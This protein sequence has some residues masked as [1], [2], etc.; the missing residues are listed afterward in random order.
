M[1]FL[2]PPLSHHL[3][4]PLLPSP[5]YP[6][7]SIPSSPTISLKPFFSSFPQGHLLVFSHTTP[8]AV[9]P[10]SDDS[11]PSPPIYDLIKRHSLFLL[12]FVTYACFLAASRAY[13]CAP[14]RIPTAP[15][16]SIS[17]SVVTEGFEDGEL[18]AAFEN[19]K[20]TSYSLTVPLTIV[21]LQGSIPP[22]WMKDFIQVQGKRLKLNIQYR[23]NLDSIFSELTL[24]S[25]KGRVRPK[26]AMSADIVSIGD[27][28]LSY[29]I[30]KGLIEP[31]KNAQEQDWFRNLSQRWKVYLC[32]N[33]KGEL[34]PNGEIWAAPYRWGTM[35]I[36]YKKSKF[37]KHNLKPIEDWD[38]LWRPELGGKIAM[39][40]SPREVI[41]ATL[42]YLGAS[43]NTTDMESQVAGGR[44]A[45][46]KCLTV[47]QRQVRL[48]DGV[49]YI[50]SFAT[51]DVWVVVGW[52][53]DVI[54]AAKRMSDVAVIVPQSGT[55]LW[56]DIWAIPN[57]TKFKTHQI[58]GR[59]RGP[60]PIIHQWMD[61]CLQTARDLPFREVVVPGSSPLYL[62]QSVLPEAKHKEKD[63]GKP[64]L[65]TNLKEGMPPR[66]ILE[67]CEFLEPLSDK[68]IED[69]RWLLSNMQKPHFG[70]LR[71]TFHYFLNKLKANA[72]L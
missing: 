44:E 49:H 24:A 47:F 71:T 21:A 57:A 55:S 12:H 43:Y 37:K 1:G 2:Q 9:N 34:D 30:S 28:W 52:S 66:D 26:S 54:P 41:G 7:S 17:E 35:V 42:K 40:D 10:R 16:P 18:N 6:K 64:K 39:V 4:H 13:A 63:R 33:C 19:W 68:A 58:G 31:I 29:A 38:D 5:S 65:D 20:S 3:R 46:L 27:S 32:R 56:A 23:A 51:G 70:S 60:S 62:E 59:V 67:R 69:Y 72:S 61:F 25:D 22:A 11:T 8:R 15:L 50:K 14:H 53:G 36:A 45:V 48:F